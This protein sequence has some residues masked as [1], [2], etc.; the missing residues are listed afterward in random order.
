MAI[1]SDLHTHTIYSDGK[2]EPIELLE[3]AFSKGI[4]QISITD[5]NNIQ[6]IKESSKKAKDLGINFVKG[7]EIDVK[8]E[9]EG[10]IFHN[11]LLGYNFDEQ[12]LQGFMDKI[13]EL[14]T[15]YFQNLVTNLK[16]FLKKGNFDFNDPLIEM[17][18]DIGIDSIDSRLILKDEYLRKYGRRLD[19]E[20][21]ESVLNNKFLGPE[22][23]HRFIKN[24]LVKSPSKITDKYPTTWK[25]VFSKNFGEVFRISE[26]YYKSHLEAISK[27]KEAGGVSILAHPFLDSLFWDEQKKEKYFRFIDY[28][29]QNG[30]D[31]L[32]IYYYANDRYSEKAQEELNQEAEKICRKH[33]LRHTYG[34]DH[35]GGKIFLGKFGGEEVISF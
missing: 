27:I 4:K 25:K 32:E 3:K 23:I 6:C 10:E 22:I 31:G 35:H 21:V 29:V 28:L 30:L 9:F 12:V 24:N 11:H 34:S 13:K 19:D 20:S 1:I 5:H 26:V 18:N 2:E 7:V 15:E 33:N 16:S 8:L 14:N 17:K